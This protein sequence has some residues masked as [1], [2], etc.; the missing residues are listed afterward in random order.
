MSVKEMAETVVLPPIGAGGTAEIIYPITFAPA[1]PDNRK[2]E[3]ADRANKAAAAGR[4]DDAL[5][6]AERGLELT[7]LD[8]TFRR[9]LI[10]VAG[11]AACHRKREAKARHYYALASA[12][13]EAEIREACARDGGI[14]L[15]QRVRARATAQS[16]LSEGRFGCWRPFCSVA[17]Y[18]LWRGG[19]NRGCVVTGIITWARQRATAEPAFGA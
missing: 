6:D 5:R 9:K 7:S 18:D 19:I 1:P 17:A 12:T 4:W 8:G 13:F 11:V 14:D 15:L 2:T 3:L 10:A 16:C